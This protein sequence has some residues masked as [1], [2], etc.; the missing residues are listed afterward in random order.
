M[1][2]EV[3]K[4]LEVL[5]R[6]RYP[7]IFIVSWEEK[8]VEEAL[9]AIAQKRNKGL[10][11]WTATDGLKS[12]MIQ[13]HFSESLKHPVAVLDH[14]IKSKEPSVIFIL[15]DFHPFL[16]EH[17]I[18]RKL[19]DVS[20]SIRKSRNTLI[21]LGPELKIPRELEKIISVL[22]YPLPGYPELE[23]LL[24]ELIESVKKNPSVTIDL[25]PE[26][27][28]KIINAAMG[29]TRLESESAFAKAV[30]RNNRLG[31]E[32][33]DVILS[34]KEQIIRKSGILEYY[35]TSEK[36]SQIGGL[37][38]LKEWL[39]K[40]ASAFSERARD[41][42]LPQPK[43]ML[44]LGVQGCGKSLAAKV[45]S[46]LWNLPLLRLDLGQVFSGIIGSSES[47]MRRAILMAE[48]LS[49]CIL[50]ID[51]IEKGLAGTKSSGMSDGGTT[52]RIFATILSWMQEKTKPVFVIATANDISQ[53][54]PELLRK[55]RFDE[56]FFVDLPNRNEREQIFKIHL[57]KRDRKPEDFDLN[58]LTN[59]SEGYSG[60]EI[61]QAI[62]S[63]LYDAFSDNEREINTQDILKAISETFPLSKTMEDKITE[64]R[65]WAK[66]RARPSSPP[67]GVEKKFHYQMNKVE[68]IVHKKQFNEKKLS[69]DEAPPL[70][71]K[72]EEKPVEDREKKEKKK[73]R[74]FFGLSL[75]R[76]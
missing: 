30:V 19:K 37:I 61:E 4:Q 41:Y 58:Q 48:T 15:K 56:I 54:P 38:N 11:T 3:N 45:I 29:L 16:E 33:I 76:D 18:I 20:D 25:N 62:I 69:I 35:H 27:K 39:V 59:A 12:P 21:L 44:L 50:W 47:N 14:V 60:A 74:S 26:V 70:P 67:E 53:L 24:N 28:E 40:R 1:V 63:A 52:A 32:D 65:E 5:I 7:I 17:L 55:G 49:P 23:G 22:D 42:G 13:G 8:R 71:V 75:R 31:E 64:L 9:I 43:G 10:Y 66:H 2:R 46:S 36:F 72:V 73:S 34:E 68:K 57:K 51:E 6:A